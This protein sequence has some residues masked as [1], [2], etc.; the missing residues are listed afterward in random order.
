MKLYFVVQSYVGFQGSLCSTHR[1]SCVFAQGKHWVECFM[2]IST[3]PIWIAF[4]GGK[5][6]PPPIARDITW[7]NVSPLFSQPPFTSHFQ[8][9]ILPPALYAKKTLAVFTCLLWEQLFS[10][11]RAH[12]AKHSSRRLFS[13]RLFPPFPLS[14]ALCEAQWSVP[15]CASERFLPHLTPA[16]IHTQKIGMKIETRIN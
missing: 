6:T 14:P 13:L 3:W 5:E 4:F 12:K 15:K 9:Y 16:R 10:M 1:I 7:I 2:T 11:L 8:A